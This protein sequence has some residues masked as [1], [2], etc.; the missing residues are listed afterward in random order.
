MPPIDHFSGQLSYVRDDESDD[1]SERNRNR[2]KGSDD[3]DHK[4]DSNDNNRSSSSDDEENDNNN[5]GGFGGGGFGFGFGGGGGGGGGGNG[6]N[7]G[8]GNRVSSSSATTSTKDHSSTADNT[9]TDTISVSSTTA[10]VV[11]TRDSFTTP[12]LPTS[13]TSS[14]AAVPTS[15]PDN[16]IATPSSNLTQGAN[17]GL[18]LGSIVA[19]I[20]GILFCITISGVIFVITRPKFGS[21]ARLWKNSNGP[22]N[23]FSS[24]Q[25]SFEPKQQRSSSNL[26]R[27]YNPSP[28]PFSR[29]FFDLQAFRFGSPGNPIDQNAVMQNS[30]RNPVTINVEP[31]AER[32]NDLQIHQIYSTHMAPPSAMM[33]PNVARS[34]SSK[35]SKQQTFSSLSSRM[36]SMVDTFSDSGVG[37]GRGSFQTYD[38]KPPRHDPASELGRA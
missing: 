19:I 15:P 24:N 5:N 35:S 37:S 20:L 18:S 8:S 25:G 28:R 13:T 7:G 31:P 12:F 21:L 4:G 36:I 14:L 2:K 9:P 33:K 38:W 32:Y 34:I 27:R 10:T 17:H 11:I 26:Y 3:D 1:N 30:S 16:A 29:T 22:R 23:I 6:S